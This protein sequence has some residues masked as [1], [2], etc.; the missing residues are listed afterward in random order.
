M[1]TGTSG[2]TSSPVINVPATQALP[3]TT[4]LGKG[5]QDD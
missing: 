2:A 1:T 3:R 5:G 4:G